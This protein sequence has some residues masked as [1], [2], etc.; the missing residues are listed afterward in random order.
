MG[1][2]CVS[3][4][5][6]GLLSR[7]GLFIAGRLSKDKYEIGNNTYMSLLGYIGLCVVCM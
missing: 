5:V 3:D 7:I 1:A 2:I 6:F 4:T